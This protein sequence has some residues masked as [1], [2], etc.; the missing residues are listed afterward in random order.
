MKR[1]IFTFVIL[2][3]YINAL[4]Q[5][6]LDR[7]KKDVYTLASDSFLGREPVTKGDTLAR[8]YILSQLKSANVLLFNDS[9]LQKVPLTIGYSL[10]DKNYFSINNYTLQ[11]RRDYVP[12]KICDT[13]SI[14]A[15]SI[16][17]GY[18]LYVKN[19]SII[20]DDYRKIKVKGKVVLILDGSPKYLKQEDLLKQKI[21]LAQEKEAAGVVILCK[22]LPEQD[23][24]IHHVGIPV[25]FLTLQAFEE[26]TRSSNINVQELISSAN[27]N[28]FKPKKLKNFAINAKADFLPVR[29]NSY[30]IIA[31][32]K[33]Y[34][35]LL[36]KEFI[37]VGAHYDHLGTSNN[38]IFNG[39]D[40]NASG[41]AG[42]I[43]LARI[44]E[45][46]KI[47]T[48]RSI[49]WVLFTAEEKGLIGSKAFVDNSPV[50]IEKIKAMINLDMIGRMNDTNPAI[51]ISGVGSC[52]L[53]SYLLDSLSKSISF[54][55][56]AHKSAGGGSDHD[57]FISKGIPA[58]F[59]NSGIHK[60][61]HTSLDDADKINYK[62][63]VDI[64]NF[65]KELIVSL[66]NTDSA[67]TY[68]K[69]TSDQPQ[70]YSR[71]SKISLGIIP[72]ITTEVKGLR[73]EGVRSNTPAAN[74]GLQKGD[75]IVAIN[76]K[77]V[78]NIYDYMERL[79]SLSPK[80]K[81]Q[82]EIIRNNQ[83]LKLK[84]KL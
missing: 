71:R 74:A 41:T 52:S 4:T 45:L 31:M 43:E 68:K 66:A 10:S 62:G 30:N 3:V 38:K 12:L 7:L 22:N 6:D 11:F 47:K 79:N 32:T 72:D 81:I 34:D 51:S 35:S 8:N 80:K 54:K 2:L 44:F 83:Q 75:I 64:V 70:S 58:L 23:K 69:T 5:A 77:P 67:L 18:G 33:G 49:L 14:Y 16:F 63:M 42:V 50:D 36:N 40:D 56:K 9:G 29:S 17:V 55:I 84:T 60:D 24:K 57:S 13:D 59:F 1:L 78:K 65:A 21:L 46:N 39:A 53:F 37:V 19:D 48:R 28:N 27:K 25:F 82:I 61:Y 15:S 76:K 20:H 73:V 26:Y